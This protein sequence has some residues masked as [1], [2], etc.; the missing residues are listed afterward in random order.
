MNYKQIIKSRETREKILRVLSF[1]PD[2]P[3]LRVQYFIKT[4]RPLHLK[5]PVR[6]TEKLQWYKLYY[7]DP[8]MICCVDKCD[9]RNYVRSRGYEH[10]LNRCLG[11]YE[12]FEEIEIGK[13]P[14][15]FVLKD[16][17]GGGGNAVILCREKNDLDW[18]Y[19]KQVTNSWCSRP[20]VR[21]GGR[22]WPYYSGKK[23]RILV[24][25][26]LET[27]DEIGLL[28]Y[29]FFCFNGKVEFIYICSNRRGGQSVQIDIV[30]PEYR[31]LEVTRVG[32]EPIGELPAKPENFDEM[33]RIAENLS[34]EFPH[35]RVDLYNVNG[36]IRFGE[37]TFFNASGY[38]IYNPDD[39]DIDMGAKFILPPKW[40]GSVEKCGRGNR[41]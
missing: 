5:T 14:E 27:P 12:H 33:I 10:I 11:V 41:K 13:L 9:V 3:M 18:S 28:D 6:F 2:N 35:V 7:R 31:K 34:M 23:H 25:E 16:T 15:Q 20:L 32:D 8:K 37:L 36:D 29:K 1:I 4:G 26:Y 24:E 39:F 19:I 30:S 38:M 21:D 17:L 40:Q 22:E